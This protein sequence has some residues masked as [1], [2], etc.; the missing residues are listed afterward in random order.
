MK[1]LIFILCVVFGVVNLY[2][3]STVIVGKNASL[4]GSVIFGHNEDDGGK[5]VVNVWRV[6]RL[7]HNPGEILKLRGG[8]EIPQIK[9]TWSLLWFQVNGLP[10]SDY[11]L[12]EWG[13]AVAS[14]ACG[15]REDDPSLTEGGIGFMLRRIVAERAETAR[16]GV[17]IAG[18]LLDRFGYASLGR[19]LII[20]DSEEGWVLSIVAGKHWVA[21]RVPD[22]G[23]VFIPNT[24]VIRQIN[25]NDDE[26]FITSEKNVLK[27]AIEREWY[28]PQQDGDFD[29]A[30]SYMSV[31]DI[32]S[33]FVKRGYDTRQWRAQQL[34]TGREVSIEEAKE[35]GLP[36]SVKPENKISVSDVMDILRDHYEDT[37]YAPANVKQS[38]FIFDVECETCRALPREIIINPNNTNERTICTYTTVHSTVAQ[39]RRGMSPD[40]GSVLWTCFGRPDFHVYVPWYA[41]ISSI[42][43]GFCNTPGVEDYKQAIKHHFDPLPETYTYDSEAAFW[44]INDLENLADAHYSKSEE[45]IKAVWLKLE[46]NFFQ[47]Q[48][49]IEQTALNIHKKDPQLAN[50]YLTEHTKSS[51]A[52]SIRLTKRLI[53]EL[54]TKFYH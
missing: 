8:G 33:N 53:T 2:P 41:G 52:R 49:E 54:K 51:A 19:T 17:E 39:L 30:Y 35:R 11:Y 37:Q 34:V 23:I 13:V 47:I 3:C 15:S 29:F 1:K 20:C 28:N 6:P 10:F 26:N 4:D 40:I 9:Q 36:F 50:E 42:P 21:Q 43:D 24:Y 22:D 31:P 18:K 38:E 46:N 48:S 45:I 44:I 25:F 14:D 5:R 32:N 16:E 27:Y 12:N 7:N